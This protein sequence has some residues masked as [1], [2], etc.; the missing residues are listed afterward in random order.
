MLYIF[1]PTN[2]ETFKDQAVGNTIETVVTH[3]D[4]NKEI[5]QFTR[6]VRKRWTQTCK[7]NIES[8][9]RIKILKKDSNSNNYIIYSRIL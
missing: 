6:R 1:T 4:T 9:H 8:D 7:N 3:R 5:C 2:E